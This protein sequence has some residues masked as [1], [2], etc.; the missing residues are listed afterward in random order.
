MAVDKHVFFKDVAKRLA[1]STLL[2]KVDSVVHVEDKDDIW[3]W[4]QLL[5]KY[6]P[7]RY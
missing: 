1:A 2:Y 3:F 6:R 4:E 5:L 7:G